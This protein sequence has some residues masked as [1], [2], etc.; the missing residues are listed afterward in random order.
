MTKKRAKEMLVVYV[1][2][3]FFYPTTPETLALIV[4]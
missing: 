3:S 2:K 4:I 1:L